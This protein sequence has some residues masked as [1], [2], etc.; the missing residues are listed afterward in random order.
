MKRKYQNLSEPSGV[1]Q[2]RTGLPCLFEVSVCIE[3]LQTDIKKQVNWLN[4][5]NTHIKIN[6][7]ASRLDGKGIRTIHEVVQETR[8]FV[9]YANHRLRLLKEERKLYLN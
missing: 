9:K 8:D 5:P 6:S 3:E 2:S 4:D 7:G 1:E